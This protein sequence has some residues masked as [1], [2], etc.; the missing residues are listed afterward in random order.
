MRRQVIEGLKTATTSKYVW[1]SGNN[2][3]DFLGQMSIKKALAIAPSAGL[4][5]VVMQV[6]SFYAIVIGIL[7][8]LF[9][10]ILFER[11]IS[12]NTLVKKFIGALIM[13]SGVYMLLM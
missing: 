1:F 7:L 4:V 3:L 9:Y 13:F 11:D 5:T 6:Q 8:T 2:L 10:R 12:A